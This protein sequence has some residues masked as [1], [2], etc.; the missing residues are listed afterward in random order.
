MW[1]W[2]LLRQGL[3]EAARFGTA[4]EIADATLGLHS[5][6]LSSPFT[7]VAAR[8]K[9]PAVAL[10][11]FLPDS[12][13]SLMTVR[14]MRKTLHALP[15]RLAATAHSA[16]L[17]FRERD[18]L[19]AVA[20]AGV[21]LRKISNTSD[22]LRRL[23]AQTGPLFHRDIETR[24]VGDRRTIQVIRLAIKLA[25]ERGVLIYINNTTGWN[26]EN[27]QFAL[28]AALYPDLDMNIDRDKATCE[29]VEAYFDRYGPASLRDVVWWSGLSRSAVIRGLRETGRE[30]ISL[31][32]GW[33]DSLLYMFR[34]RFEEFQCSEHRQCCTGTNFIAHEDVAL[35]AYFETRRRYLG[36]VPERRVFNQIGE[37]LP[38]ILVDGQVVGKWKWDRKA[39]RVTWAVE[40]GYASPQIRKQIKYNAKVLSETLRLGWRGDEN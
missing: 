5:A 16:T 33:A 11:L 39:M 8:G 2:L 6:R 30:V 14:C 23:L 35:K 4:S 27:R 25:W 28:A 38:T 3:S 36:K 9:A 17:H 22:L 10:N 13:L 20:N 34:D 7:T 40:P 32:S 37:V 12:R 1:N 24:L 15:L 26:K 18:A 29:L 21:S 19:R 31:R